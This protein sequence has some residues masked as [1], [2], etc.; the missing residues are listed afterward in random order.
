M[1][2]YT[3]LI[4]ALFLNFTTLF[5]QEFKAQIIDSLTQA[6]I[7]YAAIQVDETSG[8]I[9]NEEGFFAINFEDKEIINL[10]I[11]CLGYESKV[12]SV[13]DI[14]NNNFVII[15]QEAINTLE[16]VYINETKPNVDSIIAKVNLHLKDNYSSGYSSHEIF[17]RATNFTDF[18]KL[19]FEVDKASSFRKKDHVSANNSLDSLSNVVRNSKA[20]QFSDYLGNIVVNDSNKAKL[21]VVKA[22]ELLDRQNGFSVE[23]LQEKAQN[24]MLKYLDQDKYYKLKSGLFKLED[25]LNLKELIEED[26]NRKDE[27]NTSFLRRGA[28]N[29]L[30]QAKFYD[31]SFLSKI[32]NPKLYKHTLEDLT[33]YNGDFIYVISYLPRKAKS[34]FSGKL[35]I[36]EDTYAVIRTDYQYSKGKRGSKLNLRLLLGVKF[37]QNVRLGTVI[38]TKDLETEKYTPQYIKEEDGA[39]FFVSRPLKFIEQGGDKSKVKFSFK[40]EGNTRNKEELLCI[41]TKSITL[42]AYNAF[43]EKKK[44]PYQVLQRYDPNIWKS[45]NTLE[46]LEEMKRFSSSN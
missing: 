40:V 9:S 42:E 2:K 24:I 4:G 29:L 20:K 12:I 44:T 18:K 34:K 23:G 6:P 5:A 22:T 10:S 14:K 37:N 31:N 45:Q 7:P 8:A 36:T 15:L 17:Y 3:L 19:D 30:S 11:S 38:Y 16:E 13:E 26:E 25:S 28:N 32:L 46:P 35:Y 39:Y 21:N 27:H 43:T 41:S 1:N 33:Y